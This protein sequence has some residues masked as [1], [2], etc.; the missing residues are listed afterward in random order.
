MH[1]GFSPEL[2][3]LFSLI[4]FQGT[5]VVQLLSGTVLDDLAAA[6]VSAVGNFQKTA[7]LIFS[8][9]GARG[10]LLEPSSIADTALTATAG[11]L[12]SFHFS[13]SLSSETI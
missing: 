11:L 5:S 6:Y 13:L 12:L 10:S 9:L 7:H 8:E 3:A 2:Q 4:L 1:N